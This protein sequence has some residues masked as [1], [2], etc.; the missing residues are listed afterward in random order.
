MDLNA[1]AVSIIINFRPPTTIEKYV[2]E[3]GRAGRGGQHATAILYFNNN[4][5]ASN[6]KR[7]DLAVTQYVKTK[8]CFRSFLLKSPPELCCSNCNI[9]FSRLRITKAGSWNSKRQLRFRRSSGVAVA[10]SHLKLKSTV[11]IHKIKSVCDM[12]TITPAISYG[13]YSAIQAYLKYQ[14]YYING[15]AWGVPQHLDT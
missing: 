2:Q 8:T 9:G 4:D 10:I 1:P 12:T 11:L 14:A 5:I 7:L 15:G 6:R 13:I 3:V